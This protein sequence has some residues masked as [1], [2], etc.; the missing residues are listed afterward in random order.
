MPNIKVKINWFDL[1]EENGEGNLYWKIGV[2]GLLLYFTLFRFRL[3]LQEQDYLFVT[4]IS[5]L[6][7]ETGLTT[8]KIFELLKLFKSTG[9]LKFEGLSRWDYLLDENKN[10]QDK[11]TI[12]CYASDV[13]NTM[14]VTDENGKTKEVPVTQDDNFVNVDL[15]MMQHY[16]DLGLNYKF[17]ALYCLM[18]YYGDISNE[19][20]SNIRIEKM[21]R[22]L[23]YDKDTVH[24]MVYEL[25][26][27]YLLSSVLRKND[28]D[29]LNY[30]HKL[31]TVVGN[32]ESFKKGDLGDTIRKNIKKWDKKKENK[33]KDK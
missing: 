17:Q 4:S 8:E 15:R 3:Y 28:K 14:T 19:K 5:L 31:C 25:N 33:K 30:E 7:K 12:I 11:H 9:I 20:K 16:S 18:R 23:N 21:A 32:L 10:I 22:T 1:Q 26:R 29:G 24:K 13:P 27:R 6:R 2:E